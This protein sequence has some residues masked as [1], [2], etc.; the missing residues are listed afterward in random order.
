M[1]SGREVPS[2]TDETNGGESSS[3]ILETVDDAM[4]EFLRKVVHDREH[5]A[6][7]LLS[8]II[9]YAPSQIWVF[10]INEIRI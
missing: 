4:Q 6:I 7:Q 1:R 3:V 2:T 5:T 9:Y 8:H 10:I